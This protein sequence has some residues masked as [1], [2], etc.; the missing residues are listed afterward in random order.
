MIQTQHSRS[1]NSHAQNCHTITTLQINSPSVDES[2]LIL[3]WLSPASLPGQRVTF[4]WVSPPWAPRR[5]AGSSQSSDLLHSS[6]R[7]S[8]SLG[9]GS[10][11]RGSKGNGVGLEGADGA[12]GKGSYHP[13]WGL[14][15]QEMTNCILPPPPPS[16]RQPVFTRHL[17]EILPQYYLFITTTNQIN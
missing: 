11:N 9:P 3:R 17:L 14:M 7:H 13:S 12:G 8:L 15:E 10:P 1:P 16:S 4:S 6:R 5:Q 2:H